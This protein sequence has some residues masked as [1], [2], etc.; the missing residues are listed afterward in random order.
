MKTTDKITTVTPDECLK[1]LLYKPHIHIEAQ[2]GHYALELGIDETRVQ[3]QFAL[4]A[5]NQGKAEI[6]YEKDTMLTQ[7]AIKETL[8]K[9][10]NLLE[11]LKQCQKMSLSKSIVAAKQEHELREFYLFVEPEMRRR[12]IRIIMLFVNIWDLMNLRSP[13][14]KRNLLQS[15]TD[16]T[17]MTAIM[18]RL[19]VEIKE[20][21][22]LHEAAAKETSNQSLGE[23]VI[24][25]KEIMY[26]LGE[27]ITRDQNAL[28]SETRVLGIN[29]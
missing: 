6:A 8:P 1:I 22:Y 12:I 9:H 10:R 20:Q 25:M 26:V 14:T 18:G 13:L 23:L 3:I 7:E 28:Q 4:Q 11:L 27:I 17:M 16:R 5:P 2:N 15:L 19:Y 24:V 29:T 21:M